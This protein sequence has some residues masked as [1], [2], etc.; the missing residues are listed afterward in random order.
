MN[1]DKTYGS[2]CM[3][4]LGRSVTSSD[5]VSEL[6][7]AK[8]EKRLGFALPASLRMYYLACGRNRKLNKS[9]NSLRSPGTLAIEDGHLVFMDEN[10][11]VVS[12]GVRIED[13]K[14]ANPIIWQRNN[15]RPV[16]WY[17][18]EKNLP[19]LLDSMFSWY[20]EGGVWSR[21]E[22]TAAIDRVKKRDA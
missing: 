5:G 6:V 16:Q 4:Y 19:E 13:L 15:T 18:E 10:Q 21:A 1:F 11:D 14:S 12:W 22:E 2:L 9:H 8:A 7:I 20:S 3:K 17:S